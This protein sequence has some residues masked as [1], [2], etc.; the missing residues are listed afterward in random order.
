M[1]IN[2]SLANQQANQLLSYEAQLAQAKNSLH[3]Y[4]RKLNANW[5]GEEVIYINRAIDQ[6]MSQITAAQNQ[7][8][9]LAQDIKIAAEQIRREEEKAALINQVTIA[10]NAARKFANEVKKRLEDM[11][12]AIENEI[13]RYPNKII[14][15]SART[16]IELVR[17]E[18]TEALR[19]VDELQNR[20]NQ[21]SR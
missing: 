13:K 10:L 9:Q 8:P 17:K 16:Q 18:Y 4:H 11:M 7:L 21:V 19:K 5:Q 12:K 1:A 6:T 15:D 3:D 2:V 14:T 20:L